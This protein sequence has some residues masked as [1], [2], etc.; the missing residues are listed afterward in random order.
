METVKIARVAVAAATYTIDKPYDYLV[1]ENL[2]ER[3]KPGVRVTVPFGN[4]NRA[5][6]GIVL[7]LASD[8]KR[9]KLK[10]VKEV[11]DDESV[12]G[13]GHLA[14]GAVFLHPVRGGEGAFARRALVPGAG[15]MHAGR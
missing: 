10:A 4:G 14:A 3:A 8:S 15:G 11:L 1:P 2:E 13:P 12:L 9:P 5:S 6:E 7:A